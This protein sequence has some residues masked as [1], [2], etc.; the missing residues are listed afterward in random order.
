MIRKRSIGI[1]PILILFL[2]I[3]IH[4]Q[5]KI[6]RFAFMTDI[7]ISQDSTS[8]LGFTS[9][10]THAKTLKPDFIITGGDLIMN[11]PGTRYESVVDQFTNFIKLT[12]SLTMPVYPTVGNHDV[13]GIYQPPDFPADHPD[14]GKKLFLNVFNLPVPYYSFD[15]KGWH[16]IIFD[17]IKITPDRHYEGF[18]D[19]TQRAWLRKDLKNISSDTPIVVT[20]HIPMVSVYQQV[21]QST[22][23]PLPPSN[24]LTD[25][26]EILRLFKNKNLRLVL[27]GHL[28]IVEEMQV[29]STLF[30]TGGAVCGAWWHGAKDGFQPGFFL[31]S[32]DKNT[33]NREYITY[34]NKP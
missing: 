24:I 29:K 26:P 25:T 10:L 12:Q 32:I 31:I 9:A 2:Y 33:I 28:H 1:L 21:A 13:V 8:I 4:C 34:F 22:I 17:D 15:H 3:N 27:Q 18:I 14:A 19:S 7:H 11:N 30:L 5:D 16:F 20:L 6:F 23:K